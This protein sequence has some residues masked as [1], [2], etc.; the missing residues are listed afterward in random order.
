M[1]YSNHHKDFA[2]CLNFHHN[3]NKQ[4]VLNYP[5]NHFGPN[6]KEVL[7]FGF[8]WDSLSAEQWKKYDERYWELPRQTRHE[9]RKLAKKL[10]L[11]IIDPRIVA[12]LYLEHLEI[13]AAHLYF[14]RNISF[15]F[16]PLFFDL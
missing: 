8:Y 7:N 12:V 4:D 16:L 6:Y 3:I 15:T 13:V 10:A 14:E 11:E 2:R 5:E 1:N 9:A